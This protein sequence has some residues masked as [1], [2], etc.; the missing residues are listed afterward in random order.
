M[1]DNPVTDKTLGA[2]IAQE[3]PMSTINFEVTKSV[4]IDLT[5]EG[6]TSVT[7]SEAGDGGR[8]LTRHY[9]TSEEAREAIIGLLP[10]IFKPAPAKPS[11]RP[12]PRL[13]YKDGLARVGDNGISLAEA[14]EWPGWG[15]LW[16]AKFIKAME[17]QGLLVRR[18][19]PNGERWFRPETVQP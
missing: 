8:P 19:V 1:S 11:G 9:L 12:R 14:K 2:W 3:K 5:D 6:V 13:S 17:R 4:H 10:S 7:L 15:P 16:A 18:A